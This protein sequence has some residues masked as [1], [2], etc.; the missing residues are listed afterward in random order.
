MFEYSPS[1]WPFP[2]S[3]SVNRGLAACGVV[4]PSW[5]AAPAAVAT[6][7]STTRGLSSRCLVVVAAPVAAARATSRLGILGRPRKYLVGSTSC[8]RLARGG[9]RREGVAGVVVVVWGWGAAGT[10]T[11]AAHNSAQLQQ[12][13]SHGGVQL[14]STAPC[15][16]RSSPR[17]TKPWL[18]PAGSLA[19][20]WLSWRLLL[21]R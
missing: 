11:A 7:G 18:G 5:S 4:R 12:T 17:A 2:A 21:G 13:I 8:S 1:H 19:A 16:L 10:V 14:R 20:C 9:C 6:V 3:A 15:Q